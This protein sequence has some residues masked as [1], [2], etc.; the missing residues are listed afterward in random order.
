AR[1][2]GDHL[3]VC[4]NSDD[5][6]RRLKGPGRPLNSA[7]DRAAV[8]RSLAAVDEVVV[9][10]EDTPAAALAAIRPDLFVKGADYLDADLEE[11]AAM[12][13]WGGQVVVLPMVA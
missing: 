12:A 11:R 10:Y 1:R 9:F 3:V 5:S 8:L 2:L 4:L 13:A 7:P 6:V